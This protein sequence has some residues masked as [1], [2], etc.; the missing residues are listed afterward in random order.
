[1]LE[2]IQL[3]CELTIFAALLCAVFAC[4]IGFGLW[5]GLLIVNGMRREWPSGIDNLV[6]D[7]DD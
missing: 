3:L 4:C 2:A 5:L 6:P 1:M 7:D